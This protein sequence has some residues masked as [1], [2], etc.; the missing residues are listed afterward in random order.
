MTLQDLQAP[1]IE[2]ALARI[3]AELHAAFDGPPSAL[4]SLIQVARDRLNELANH[5]PSAPAVSVS[6]HVDLETVAIEIMAG[7]ARDWIQIR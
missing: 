2:A 4:D 3:R 6:A 5:S 1:A 7:S